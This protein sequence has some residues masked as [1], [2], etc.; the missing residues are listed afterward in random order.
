MTKNFASTGD[1]ADRI[2]QVRMAKAISES[3]YLRRRA[4]PEPGIAR[5]G[6]TLL[7]AM[8]ATTQDGI[9]ID[10]ALDLSEFAGALV[11][12]DTA[13]QI[14]RLYPN[15]TSTGSGAL[16]RYVEVMRRRATGPADRATL[17]RLAALASID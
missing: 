11:G 1:M 10:R 9:W 7:M 6:I 16:R 2:S 5:R 15:A 8:A 13:E 3:T 14:L 12:A 4:V 17:E